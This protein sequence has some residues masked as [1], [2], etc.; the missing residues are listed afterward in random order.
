MSLNYN[1]DS[2]VP[3]KS[4]NLTCTENT[5]PKPSPMGDQIENLILSQRRIFISRPIDSELA[6]EV[7][8]KIWFLEAQSEEKPVTVII[9]SPGG[10]VDAGFAIWDQLQMMRFPITTVVTGIAASMGSILALVAPKG[11]RFATAKSRIMIHQPS[12]SS[13]VQGQA[14]DLEIHARE[15]LN[16]KKLII[17]LYSQATGKSYSEIEL[18][19]ER[20]KWLSAE[21]AC[22]YGLVDKIITS[23]KEI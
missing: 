16:T 5:T 14:T 1:K 11:R 4:P 12:I 9:N 22:S 21:E 23:F 3:M 17:D 20:D 10:S 6:E 7:I 8:R 13:V 18:A 2:I 15:I 19:I